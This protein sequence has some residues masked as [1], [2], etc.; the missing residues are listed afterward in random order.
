MLLTPC[1]LLF[2]LDLF[3][4]IQV[5]AD[6]LM[7]EPISKSLWNTPTIT[8]PVS[9]PLLGHQV[10][11]KQPSKPSPRIAPSPGAARHSN[12]R[13]TPK[14]T[15]RKRLVKSKVVR[16]LIFTRS[17]NFFLRDRALLMLLINLSFASLVVMAINV[18]KN[19]IA[20]QMWLITLD[21]IYC[22]PS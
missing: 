12:V 2:C 4:E 6:I 3:Q 7:Q 19:G 22:L 5:D 16:A 11:S 1:Y 13:I 9:T 8:R 10:A 21:G 18:N 15:P 17:S 20:L 14:T